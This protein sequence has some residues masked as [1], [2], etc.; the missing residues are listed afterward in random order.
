MI[1]TA[2]IRKQVQL[3]TPNMSSM[4][5]IKD[6]PSKYSQAKEKPRDTKNIP[7]TSVKLSRTLSCLLQLL[8]WGLITF[9][10]WF[11]I[12]RL[13]LEKNKWLFLKNPISEDLYFCCTGHL[14]KIIRFEAIQ[15]FFPQ[16]LSLSFFGCPRNSLSLP[17]FSLYPFVL[18]PIQIFYLLTDS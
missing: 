8:H 13:S 3:Q 2:L 15:M 12:F 6:S 14:L 17:L 5:G 7:R 11:I 18:A 1:H 16:P 10:L 4:S 9:Y